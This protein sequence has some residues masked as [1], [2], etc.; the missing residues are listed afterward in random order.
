MDIRFA[1]PHCTQHIAIDEA[2][3]GLQIE[4][5]DCRAPLTVPESPPTSAAARPRI[6]LAKSEPPPAPSPPALPPP[7]PAAPASTKPAVDHQYRCQNPECGVTLF[8]S[9]LVTMQAGMT[10]F[11]VCPKC[12]L[13][14]SKVNQEVSF[15]SRV[16]G[17][18][19]YPFRDNG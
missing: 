6:R 12:R 11:K 5:P 8:E 7:L 4:C 16:P 1:C 17:T 10:S 18:F 19:A 14:V 15:W 2:G 3:A 9:Q 13:R